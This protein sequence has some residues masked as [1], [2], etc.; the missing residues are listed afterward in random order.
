[1]VLLRTFEALCCNND[2]SAI[3][4]LLILSDTETVS[5]VLKPSGLGI[6]VERYKQTFPHMELLGHLLLELLSGDSKYKHFHLTIFERREKVHEWI[7]SNLE[8][9][10]QNFIVQLPFCRPYPYVAELI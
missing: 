4:E 8:Y 9:L 1:M 2:A 5:C 7:N 10:N 3:E 6:W